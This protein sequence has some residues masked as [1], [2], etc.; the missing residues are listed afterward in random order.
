M[1]LT[2]RK[3]TNTELE[4]HPMSQQLFQPIFAD[5]IKVQTPF[6]PGAN[7][8]NTFKSRGWVPPTEAAMQK[9]QG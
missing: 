4:E 9:R 7:L 3:P 6:V 1:D 2:L 5:R 8:L